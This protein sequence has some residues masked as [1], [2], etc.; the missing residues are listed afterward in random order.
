M[1]PASLKTNYMKELKKCGEP[2]YNASI[3]HWRQIQY[4]NPEYPAAIKQ[5]C[6]QLKRNEPVWIT[7]PDEAANFSNLTSADQQ[8]IQLQIDQLILTKYDFVHY[9]G[10]SES[11]RVWKQMLQTEKTEGNPFH[12]KVVIVDEAHNLIYHLN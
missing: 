10:L 5:M 8:S 3:H 1:C 12:N 7:V 2:A 4:Q 9:N 11:A 6:I